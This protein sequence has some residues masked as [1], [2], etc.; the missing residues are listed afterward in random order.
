ML[1]YLYLFSSKLMAW[2]KAT[3]RGKHSCYPTSSPPQNEV[4]HRLLEIQSKIAVAKDN[5]EQQE[6]ITSAVKLLYLFQPREK[7]VDCAMAAISERRPGVNGENLFWQESGVANSPL[8]CAGDNCYCDSPG[9]KFDPEV[10]SCQCWSE[11]HLRQPHW[12][13]Q[14]FQLARS[15]DIRC[16]FP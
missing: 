2:K 8:S 15:F 4:H 12:F 6:L 13:P 16:T 11:A 10:F 14:N 1:T 9:G 3:R 7:Q 5:S